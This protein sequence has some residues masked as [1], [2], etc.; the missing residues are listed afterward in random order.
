VIRVVVLIGTLGV[1]LG[2][3]A[4]PVA[5]R[6]VVVEGEWT[7]RGKVIYP[8]A[9]LYAGD[10]VTARGAPSLLE[11][12]L[13][14]GAWMPSCRNGQGAQCQSVRVPAAEPASFFD[15]MFEA[16]RRHLS[17]DPG[18]QA[19]IAVRGGGMTLGEHVVTGASWRVPLAATQSPVE[20]FA[21]RATRMDAAGGGAC[22]VRRGEEG[23]AIHC[24]TGIGLYEVIASSRV[25]RSDTTRVWVAVVCDEPSARRLVGDLEA[26]DKEL[27]GRN[28]TANVS[29]GS[30]RIVR[31]VLLMQMASEGA[32]CRTR[33][34]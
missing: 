24:E 14:N 13:A 8:G 15:R 11:V 6:A 20:A 21:A 31:R 17:P 34:V 32:L 3:Q 33:G 19:S 9:D 10:V 16:L 4:R 12:M 5:G 27:A 30:Y 26:F 23:S 1:A 29:D 22:S 7:V 28:P 2:L 18:R 25:N